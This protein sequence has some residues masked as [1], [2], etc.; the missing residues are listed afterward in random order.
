MIYAVTVSVNSRIKKN[1]TYNDNILTIILIIYIGHGVQH[2][3]I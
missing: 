1:N 3:T 2:T